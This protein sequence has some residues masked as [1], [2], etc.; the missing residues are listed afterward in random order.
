MKIPETGQSRD[1]VLSTLQSF[2]ANDLDCRDGKALA[3]VFHASEEASALAERAYQM[4]LWANALDPRVFPSAMKLENEIVAMAA[5]HLRGDSEV[6]GNFTSGGTESVLLAVKTA[7]DYAR[8]T[9][10]IEAPEMVLPVTAHPCFLK[11]AHYFGIKPVLVPVDPTT[12]TTDVDAMRAAITPN[13]VLL[14]SSAPSYAHGV[15]DPIE[16]IGKLA[17]EHDI[18]FHVDG[19]IGGFQ[20]P[21]FR[22]L[23]EDIPD[24]DFKV[25]GVTSMSM[26]FHKYAYCPKGASVVLYRNAALR[27]HQIFT[28]SGWPGYS[29]VNP[30]IQSSKSGGPMAATWAMLHFMGM[31]GYLDL[32]RPLVAARDKV[33]AGIAAIPEL[34]VLGDPKMTLFAFGGDGVNHFRLCDAMARRGWTMHPQMQL[35]ELKPNFHIN[36]IPLNVAM[37]DQWLDELREAIAEVNSSEASGDMAGLRMALEAIDFSKLTDPQIEGLL[38]IGG[39][40]DGDLPEGDQAEI[41]QILNDLP[42]EVTDRVLTLFYNRLNRYKG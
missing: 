42:S 36:L 2:G 9:K 3:F 8:A 33:K 40:S 29:M 20:L 1:D 24:F 25:P 27:Q 39:L 34:E 14:A 12:F 13:T 19:C 31:D 10:G 7:R 11:G 41:N 17:L 5:S 16:D 23:G 6:V 35:G 22:E 4:Y 18:L 28:Y 21:L 37:I 26:D 30:T 38:E 15:I 32:A